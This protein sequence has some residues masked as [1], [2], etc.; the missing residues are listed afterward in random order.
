MKFYLRYKI[1]A[2]AKCILLLI[3][4]Q[5]LFFSQ[6]YGSDTKPI[7]LKNLAAVTT[8]QSNEV[9]TTISGVV[10]DEDGNLLIGASVLIKNTTKGTLTDI[11]GSYSISVSENTSD[12][13]F[14]VS[15]I[16]YVSKEVSVNGRT[17]L[18]IIL[19]NDTQQLDEVVVIG[20]GTGTK[21]KF[22]GSVSR[23]DNETLNNYSTAN[24]EQALL[25]TVSGVQV[26][27]NGKNPGDNSV[28]QIRGVN[29]LTAGSSPLIVV[30]GNPLTEGSSLSSIN[31]ND[32]ESVS[33]LKDAASAAIYGSRA[34]NGVILITT[35]K[36][37]KG[38]L[39]VTYDG[40]I[41]I[42]KRVDN[43]ELA[44]AY[45]TSQ[46]DSD[47]RNFGY[48]SGGPNRFV[49]DDNATRDANGGGK[50]SRIP[51]YLQAYLDGEQGLTNTD[52]ND[53]VF[54]EAVQQSH[55]ISI[56]GGNEN[57]DFSVSFGFLDQ[58]NIII[59]SDYNRYTNNIRFNTELSDKVKFGINTNL[60]AF[61][62]NPTGSAGWSESKINKIVD[63]AFSITLM[64][65]YYE[66]RNEDGS[67]NIAEQIDDNNQNWDGPIS[68]N[69]IA[70]AELSDYTK[71]GFRVFGS[72]FVEYEPIKGLKLKTSFGGDFNTETEEYFGPST[73]GNYRTPVKNNLTQASKDG[74]IRKNF[75]SEN[76]LNYS[77]EFN[78][79]GFDFLAGYSYQSEFRNRT[80]LQSLDFPDDNLRNL[81]G[82]TTINSTVRSS[83]WALESY[84]G[85]IQYSL[86]D[87]YTLSGSLRRDGSSRFGAN[88]KYGNFGSLSAGWI[89][90]NENFFPKNSAIS[91]TKIRASW[92]QTGNNQIGD[93][94][95]IALISNSNY[96]VDGELQAGA[97]TSTSPNADL[98][99]EKNSALNIG[100]DLGLFDNKLFLT[101][102]Y[103]SSRTTDLLLDV[104]VPQQSGFTESLQN[105][106]ELKNTGIELEL[107]GR[108]YDLGPIKTSFNANFTT[109]QN[110]VVALGVGQDQIIYN[111]GVTFL[112]KVGEPIAQFYNYEIVGVYRNEADIENDPITALPGSEV[113][114]YIVLDANADGKIDA[115]DRVSQGDYNPD[116][117]YGFG[118]NFEYSGF[119]LGLQFFGIEGRKVSDNMVNR[120]ESGEGFFVPSQYYYDN[121]FSDENPDGFFRRPD[122]SSFSSAG[123]LTRSSNLA[124]LSGDYFRLRSLQLGYVLPA[125][126]TKKNGVERVRLY[127]TGNNLLNI[128]SFRGFNSD[129]LDTRS[130]ERQSLSRGYIHSTSPLTRFIAFG[131]NVTF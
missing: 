23:A 68:E 43:F 33:I 123:R 64:Q 77:K 79:H 63:P 108:G 58:D 82:A 31:T 71:E 24:F 93:F 80:F 67:L 101:A 60:S 81:G 131:A 30:D 14:I 88:S 61:N 11:G 51:N 87:K 107:S 97:Y 44:D 117:T 2:P 62:A 90:S 73:F 78:R 40:Y 130:N 42:Q 4:M 111:N 118:L 105:I 99:W 104:P 109:N 59:D 91:F 49:T 98:S 41:G 128:S 38:G 22:N 27:S 119:D 75:I 25:G 29:T 52:W 20:Y 53:A 95:S 83:E 50:R 3:C 21:E 54:R 116:F 34:S 10:S 26:L 16:G 8:L 45:E 13:I 18:D 106:G 48:I 12:L 74:R 46:F 9:A 19:S 126:W 6:S 15:Y 115:D 84:F 36:G 100:F 5:F 96:V 76:T 32:I 17:V 86:D 55:Y 72:T 39:R 69:T 103:F 114:D 70:Q 92:G 56:L 85:R 89:L 102:E 112:T 57:S 129:G 120:V 125:T 28:V 110:E 124:V 37:T 1:F 7:S 35:K 127:V 121:Y 122:F 47:A 94:G 66:I 113:G 65:P